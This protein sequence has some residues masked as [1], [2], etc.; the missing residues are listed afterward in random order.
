MQRTISVK[1]EV[2]GGFSEYLALCNTIY[3]RYV[4][5]AFENRTYSKATAHKELYSKFRVEFPTVPS[6]MIQS[7]RDTAMEAVKALKFKFKPIKKP[8]SSI[9][10]DSR[11]LALR[12]DQLSL[13]WSGEGRVKQIISI[14][15]FFK[16]RTQ[17]WKCQSA[18]VGYNPQKR[19]FKANLIF[20][21]ET[22]ATITGDGVVGIDRGLYN[23]VSLS[24]GFRVASAHIR[25][26]KRKVLFQKRQ[27][28]AKGTR[29]AQRKLRKLSGY[30]KRFSLNE[31]HRI[32]KLLAAMP[33]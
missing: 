19:Q 26:N 13:S 24:D 22:P 15:K 11:T 31:N 3:N 4:D 18:T 8:F 28:Q 32:S 16:D 12:G 29:S 21:T 17:N 23:I 7:I 27:L 25:K 5:W 6:A 33:Y 14:P 10:Y 2:P 20:Q 1:I 9:R 30:E